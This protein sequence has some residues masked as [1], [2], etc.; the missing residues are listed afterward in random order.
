LNYWQRKRTPAE[1][2]PQ[3]LQVAAFWQRFALLI[4]I[5]AAT[6]LHASA[7]SGPSGRVTKPSPL[8]PL[9]QPFKPK[10][11]SST[12]LLTPLKS[13]TLDAPYDPITPRQSLRWFVAN[14]VGPQTLTGE[15]FESVFGTSLNRPSEYGPR[16]GG[17]AE[18]YGMGMTRVAGGNAIEA[19]FGRI[20]HE[21]P[22]YFCVPGRPLKARIGNVIKLTFAVRAGDNS[23][24]P[25]FSRSMAIF[26]NNLL[27]DTWRV[28]SEANTQDALLR[29]SEGFAG[30][31]A[32]NAFEEFW[33]DIKRLVF[34]RHNDS[35]ALS[36]ESHN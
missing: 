4:V 36:G 21:D 16:W 15:F 12:S 31:M 2:G 13:Q 34:R 5:F 35:L 18:R 8:A 29:T 1:C 20:L 3:K 7:Q 23:F 14:T 30:R 26:G 32:A 22:R 17:F 9:H 27:S 33:P 19:G 25:A 10:H 6:N 11:P 24:R 28:H